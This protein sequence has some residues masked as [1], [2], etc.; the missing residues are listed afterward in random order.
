MMQLC[1]G[2]GSMRHLSNAEIYD[3]LH[4]AFSILGIEAGTTDIGNTALLT[5][6]KVIAG[7]Q[8]AI[9]ASD[10][11]ID[12]RSLSVSAEVLPPLRPLPVAKEG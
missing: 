10:E 5:A 9:V 4:R 3:R 1:D 12:L 8:L 2:A 11:G 7:L 6:R